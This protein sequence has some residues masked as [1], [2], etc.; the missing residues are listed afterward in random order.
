MYLLS[1]KNCFGMIL[2]PNFIF[3]GSQFSSGLQNKAFNLTTLNI[4]ATNWTREETYK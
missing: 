1:L 2:Y 3:L 4:N